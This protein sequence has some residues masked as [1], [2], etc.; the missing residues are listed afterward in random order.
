MDCSS[1]L[2]LGQISITSAAAEAL[3]GK[4][5]AADGF[6]T[7]HQHG[8]WGDVTDE[9]AEENEQALRSGGWV[10]SAYVLDDGEI[11]WVTTQPDRRRT[12]VHLAHELRW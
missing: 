11:L 4:G 9:D 3:G 1:Q 12:I 2:E 5:Q 8:D 7:R 6:I 10:R